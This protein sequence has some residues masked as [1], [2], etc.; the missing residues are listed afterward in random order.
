M[1]FNSKG[2]M[3]MKNY[4]NLKTKVGIVI[5]MTAALGLGAL[6]QS[7]SASASKAEVTID[8]FTF[9]AP[10]IT[11]PVGTEV[12][13]INRDDMPHTI[14]SDDKTLKSKALDTDERFSFTF[15]AA[16]TYHYFCPIHP[17]MTG[18]VIVK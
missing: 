6:G 5:V 18:E 16:G 13:W 10:T 14:A 15:A 3:K 12:T 11:V 17:K 9:Q 4:R 1:T 7:N 8:N 2:E